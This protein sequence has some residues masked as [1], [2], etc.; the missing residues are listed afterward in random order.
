M[1]T[2]YKLPRL[3]I[4]S[5]ISGAPF[6]T[7]NTDQTHYIRNV[8]RMNISDQVRI[9]NGRDGEW[10]AQIKELSKKAALLEPV[11]QIKKQ[12]PARAR[13]H[14]LFA[15]IKKQRMDFLVEKAVELGA[16]DLHLVLTHHTEARK[17]NEERIAGQIIEA[18]EQCERLDIP[19]L[20]PLTK[21]DI[22]IVQWPKDITILAALEREDA[23][24]LRDIQKAEKTAFLIGPEG[25]FNKDE[26]QMLKTFPYVKAVSLGK[27]IL[28]AETAALACLC[29]QY[30]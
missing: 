30:K 10:T 14:L 16:T 27:N 8:M 13:V 5:D 4:S 21:L 22:K 11:K 1:T 25:G 24:P 19:T 2:T 7:L 28:R 3:Y 17:I 6:L 15:P 26:K 23:P 20:H 29:M 12:P 9:F 18:T